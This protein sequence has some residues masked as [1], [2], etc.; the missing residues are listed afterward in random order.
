MNKKK[1]IPAI[2]IEFEGLI[3]EPYDEGYSLPCMLLT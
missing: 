2:F 3:Y 1:F